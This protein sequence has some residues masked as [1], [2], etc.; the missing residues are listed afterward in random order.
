MSRVMTFLGALAL[1]ASLGWAGAP[2]PV[3]A[4]S[5]PIGG[6]GGWDYVSVEPGSHNVYVSHQSRM[7][8]IDPAAGK[9]IAEIPD[10][11]G[12]HGIAFA[13]EFNRG[14][15]TCGGDDTLAIIDLKTF[16][17]L[18]R[19]KMTGGKPDGVVYDPSTERIFVMNGDGEN[20]TV[21]DARTQKVLGTVAV[22]GGPE[23][24]QPDLKGRLFVNI[25]DKNQV[26]VIDTRSLK[27]L[28][29]W[30]LGP[31]K[32]PTGMAID[33]ERGRLFVGCRSGQM[34]VLD[35]ATGGIVATVPIGAGV[36]AC[37]F[38]PASRRVFASCKDGTVSV[39]DENSADSFSLAG[40]LK[41]EPG[42]KTMTLDPST[43][44]LF[45]PASGAGGFR[46]LEF[47]Q[48]AVADLLKPG[49]KIAS[50]D[51]VLPNFHRVDLGL[52]GVTLYRSASPVRALVKAGGSDLPA[53][54]GQVLVHA[55]QLGIVTIIS[56]EDPADAEQE[57]SKATG[58]AVERTAAQGAGIAFHSHPMH[59]A[60]LKDMTPQEIQAWL[61]GVE[62][63]I[64][65]SAKSGAVLVHCAAGHDRTGLVMAYLRI[66]VD[67]WPAD[68]AIAEMRA[69]GHN[70]PKFSSNGGRS[71][72]HEEFLKNQYPAPSQAKVNP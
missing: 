47:S 16:N 29:T 45:V 34:V 26:R 49:E 14:F 38:D 23:S 41:T 55:R 58:V 6:T 27:V 15:I 2:M 21:V 18:S 24:A 65:A 36:D 52:A 70:W 51:A 66:K 11:K 56:L 40:V 63:D 43:H 48:A 10:I 50:E 69:M 59:N 20:L 3:P 7:H 13:Q 12:V 57:G 4:G 71:S 60:K 54:A 8:V 5:V 22:G 30:S 42:S 35:L 1:T 25:E 61:Q 17:T 37:C 39:I 67:Q 62:Q 44:M 32:T 9:V 53:R 68:R 33:L 46:L 72:W 19:L 28:D 31:H 64:N